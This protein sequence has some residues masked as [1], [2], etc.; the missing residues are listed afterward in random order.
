M[1]SSAVEVEKSLTDVTVILNL[2]AKA[3]ENFSSQLFNTAKNTGQ[4]F[5]TVSEAAVELSRQGL[6]AEETLKRI[7]DAMILTRLSGIMLQNPLR[8]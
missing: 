6:G 5:Q 1:I 8:H 7:N 3:L 4:S 2:N